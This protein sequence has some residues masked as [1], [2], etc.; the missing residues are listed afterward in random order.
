MGFRIIST[1]NSLDWEPKWLTKRKQLG[2]YKAVKMHMKGNSVDYDQGPVV[3][4]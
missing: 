2:F 4:N 1:K 3:Q